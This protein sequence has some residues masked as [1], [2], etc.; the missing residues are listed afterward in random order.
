MRGTD[1]ENSGIRQVYENNK[2]QMY[3]A[4]S[5]IIFCCVNN[6]RA[7]HSVHKL[8]MHNL[9]VLSDSITIVNSVWLLGSKVLSCEVVCAYKNTIGNITVSESSGRWLQPGPFAVCF[10][11]NATVLKGAQTYCI[12]NERDQPAAKVCNRKLYYRQ[13]LKKLF[14]C[15]RE[16]DFDCIGL[17]YYMCSKK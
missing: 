14:L 17:F 12:I 13:K 3:V 6:F 8:D 10:V 1:L 11:S 15:V 2:I 7:S 9:L 4:N 16:G 5:I